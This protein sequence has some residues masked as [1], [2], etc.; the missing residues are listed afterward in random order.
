MLPLTN[1][2]VVA[3]RTG[4]WPHRF[5]ATRQ[6]ADLGARRDQ[7]RSADGGDFARGYDHD[8]HGLSRAT[9][10]SAQRSKESLTLDSDAP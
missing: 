6:L 5:C 2:H 9:S 1:I 10:S 4:R 3:R 8:S 7:Y